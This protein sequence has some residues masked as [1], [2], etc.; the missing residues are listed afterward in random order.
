MPSDVFIT[1]L[2]KFL[3][4]APVGNEEMEEIL[5]RIHGRPSRA[6]ARVLA[7]NGIRTRH[8]AIDKQ[9]RTLYRASEMAARAVADLISRSDVAKKDIDFLAAATAQGD[10]CVPGF[11]SLVHAEIAHGPCEIASLH[12]VCASGVAA[13]KS[14][15]L[16]V[17]AGEK[18][19]AV[20][21]ASEL[22]SRL[23]KASRYEPSLP[24]GEALPFDVEFLRWMLS[25]G[26]GAALFRPA[27]ASRGP[28]LRVEWIELESHAH[29]HETCMY[30]G[31]LKAPG[32]RAGDGTGHGP[33]WLDYPTYEAA[34]AEGALY[35]RQDIRLLDR[36]LQLGVDT[37]FRLVDE[38]KVDPRKVDHFVCH[39]SSQFF[40]ARILELL[41]RA[42][43]PL[44][45]EKWFSNLATRGNV[46]SASV[47]V[48][49]EELVNERP[50]RAG[51][52][53][54][55]MIP[56]S[57]RFVVSFMLLTVVEPGGGDGARGADARPLPPP[58]AVAPAG[59]PA[60]PT[61]GDPRLERLVRQLVRV[62]IDFETR[63]HAV[64]IVAKLEAGRFT[65]EDYR[66][67]LLNLRQQV[68]EGARWIARAASNLDAE[69]FP[70]R[71]LFLQHAKEEHRDFELLERNFVAVGGALEEIRGAAKNVG[72]E[73]LSAWMFHRAS[74]EN[75]LDL[76]GAMFIIEGLGSRLAARW[77]AAIRDQL[78]LRDEDVSFLL[79]H[80]GNDD[81]HLGKLEQALTAGWL[82]DAVVDRIVKTAKV[83][84]R[85]YLLQLEELGNV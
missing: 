72:S 73:A 13:M 22:P 55:V 46:G 69:R 64:P 8:Y 61:S 11:A 39:Y 60:L 71:S 83:T 7:Q 42:G 5:G 19:S 54:L 23:F 6:K 50:L 38:G 32:A 62:W 48:L 21:C 75:P 53:I 41:A 45:E 3:P 67:L 84:A 76:L 27:P 80:G 1:A 49:L 37:F 78:G 4:G 34:A 15:Y 29:A 18:Q 57:G 24:P 82:D 66:A 44:P 81:A 20:A 31:A 70:L 14:A 58:V 63:L 40:R 79:Y 26:A 43:A 25:D 17:R 51:E 77:G 47:F 68:V 12:G 74:A 59:P 2:G 36:L 16:Q 35:L 28:S 30:A 10:L 56:E 33:G 65:R 52:T 85:L 9:G